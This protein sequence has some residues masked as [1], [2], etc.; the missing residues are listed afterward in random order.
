MLAATPGAERGGGRGV[1]LGRP[2]EATHPASQ[3]AAF[4]SVSETVRSA[5]QTER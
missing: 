5:P 3:Q 2:V 4:E 1:E